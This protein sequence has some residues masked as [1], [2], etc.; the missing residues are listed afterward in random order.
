MQKNQE[1][2]HKA[3]SRCRFIKAMLPGIRT[4]KKVTERKGHSEE[5]SNKG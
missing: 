1:V 5:T 4:R 2:S 3:E